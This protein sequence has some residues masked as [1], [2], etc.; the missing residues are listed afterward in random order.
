M[1][2]VGLNY[3]VAAYER[4]S[5]EDDRKDESSSIESQKMIIESFAKFNNLKIIEHYSDD[6]FT[7]SNFN[8][9]GF[10]RLKKAIEDNLI[11]CVIVKDL[12][13]LGRE[14]YETGAYIEEY[15]LSKNIRFIAINDGYDSEVGDSMLGIRLSVN[16]LYLRDTSKKIRST[17]D[18]KRK[19]GDY[20]GSFATFGYMKNPDNPKQLIR[21]PD[22]DHVVL[23]IFEWIASGV[24]TSTVA[25]RLTKQGIPIP[26]IYKKEH[27]QNIQKEL[28]EG[29]GIW[30]PQTVKG[31]ASNKMYLGHMVQGRWK[32]QSYN[33]KRLLELPESQWIIVENT[34]EPIVTQELFDKVQK[35]LDKNKRYAAKNE[36]KHLFQ[37]LL[38]CKECGHNMS[39]TAKKN[40]NSIS[41]TA[42]CNYYSKYSKYGLCCTHRINYQDLEEDLLRFLKEVGKVFLEQF[43]EEKLITQAMNIRQ[44][45]LIETERELNKIESEKEKNQKIIANLYDDRLNE[46]IST[47]QYVLMSKKYDE[48]LEN[49]EKKEEHLRRKLDTSDSVDRNEEIEECRTLLKQFMQFEKPTNELMFQL[50]DKIEVDKDKNVEVYFKSDISKYIDVVRKK[51]E[52]AV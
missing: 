43:D 37:G 10:E 1:N 35:E 31:I 19:K 50:I 28:N 32:K 5:R 34:H 8:R 46:I 12:S 18:A 7:G 44:K 25:H 16:D 17:F 20:I 40:K 23:Q 4:L 15:F 11:N 14:L 27:R 36:K 52:I 9:P 41:Y 21:D 3:K 24:G 39:I 49:L 38:K 2:G 48:I 26:S 13:R 30:R 51:G 45:E 47:R 22:V 6:G 42:E 29:N 33:S